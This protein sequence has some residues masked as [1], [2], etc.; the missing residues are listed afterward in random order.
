LQ[1]DR[2]GTGDG[3]SLPNTTATASASIA[4]RLVLCPTG[5]AFD[6]RFGWGGQ[7]FD[8]GG[9]SFKCHPDAGSLDAGDRLRSGP[10]EQ[11]W[12]AQSLVDDVIAN[13]DC[14]GLIRGSRVLL[15]EVEYTIFD[16]GL[17]GVILR[18]SSRTNP[19]AP[20]NKHDPREKQILHGTPAVAERTS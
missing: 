10:G 8:W 7:F 9:F 5:P 16:P 2:D 18:G 11:R 15:E 1:G 20:Y 3:V 12:L 17:S 19:P 14:D 4:R 6:L 13:Q